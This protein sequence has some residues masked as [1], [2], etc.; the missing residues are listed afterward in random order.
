[1]AAEDKV[2]TFERCNYTVVDHIL[3]NIILSMSSDYYCI[4]SIKCKFYCFYNADFRIGLGQNLHA[5]LRRL[6]HLQCFS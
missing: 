3:C 5:L 1:M 4:L 6:A 2:R